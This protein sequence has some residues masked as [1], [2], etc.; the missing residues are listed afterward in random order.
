MNLPAQLHRS[1]P[2]CLQGSSDERFQA[3][4]QSIGD[5]AIV[6]LD[7]AGQICS[8]NAGAENLH[9]WHAAEAMG[10]ELALLYPADEAARGKPQS[11]M[12]AAQQA[13]RLASYARQARKDKSSF[14]ARTVLIALRSSSGDPAGFL[15]VTRPVIS[16]GHHN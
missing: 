2:C 15:K 11:D 16:N 5:Y 4:A 14:S 1:R 7:S 6:V 9:G 3:L 13:G 10:R 12:K 8:W